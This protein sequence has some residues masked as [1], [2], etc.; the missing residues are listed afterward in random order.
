M[1]GTT[2]NLGYKVI[3]DYSLTEEMV[4][5]ENVKYLWEASHKTVCYLWL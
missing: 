5:T 2:G 4:P 3:L 1:L